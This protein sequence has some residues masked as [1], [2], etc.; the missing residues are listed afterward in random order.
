MRGSVR[1]WGAT[2]ALVLVAAACSSNSS[3]ASS[4]S[5]CDFSAWRYASVSSG[6]A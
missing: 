6:K 4:G 3:G 2:V 1:V 5:Q